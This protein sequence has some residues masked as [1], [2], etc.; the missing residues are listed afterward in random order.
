MF[1]SIAVMIFI[2]ILIGESILPQVILNYANDVNQI[3]YLVPK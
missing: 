2:P 3:R 1:G